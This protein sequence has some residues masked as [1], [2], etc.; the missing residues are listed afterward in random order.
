MDYGKTTNTFCGTPEFM[1]PEILLE[2]AY[3]RAVDW[4]A[5]GVLI[6]E[7]LLAQVHFLF[8]F[9]LSSLKQSF[10]FCLIVK[11]IVTI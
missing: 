4:W 6:Y 1:A 5:L 10:L 11:K 3:G 9:S 7:M 8:L 2:Q